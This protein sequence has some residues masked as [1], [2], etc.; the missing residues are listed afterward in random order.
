MTIPA[1]LEE[2]LTALEAAL[3]NAHPT[4]PS[5]L[6]QIHTQLKNDPA[7]V[8]ILT[9]EQIAVIVNGLK[10]QTQVELVTS[11]LKKSTTKALKYTTVDD[12]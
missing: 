3:L 5:L 7:I 10:K 6:K 9:E 2:K 8:T 1:D 11:S 12:L 4:L